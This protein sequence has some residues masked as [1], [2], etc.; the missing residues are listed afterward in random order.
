LTVVSAAEYLGQH[1]TKASQFR[2]GAGEDLEPEVVFI[3]QAVGAA[4]DYAD[5]GVEPLD[6]S[7]TD[8]V[9]RLAVCGD[10]VPVPVDHL[11]EL[12]IALQALP[13]EPRPPI[14]E[15]LAR[16]ALADTGSQHAPLSNDAPFT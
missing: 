12:F 8:L 14:L 7:Q 16:P 13:L 1:G 2:Q 11:G 15:E 10:A 5:V 9:L 6:V 3:P 4:L